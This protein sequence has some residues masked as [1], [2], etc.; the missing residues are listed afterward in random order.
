MTTRRPT[1][2]IA[3]LSLAG[4]CGT[5]LYTVDLA[6]ALLRFDW[7]PVV[8]TPEIGP[9]ADLL[10]AASIPVVDNLEALTFAPDVIHGHHALETIAALLRF[11][12]VPAVYVCHD[13][14]TWHSAPPLIDRIRTYIAVDEHCLDR[15][16]TEYSIPAARARLLPNAVDLSRFRQRRDLPAKPRRALVFSNQATD[17]NFVGAVREACRQREIELD[18]IGAAAGRQSDAPEEALGQVDLVFAKARCA[19][20]AMAVGAAVV[21]CDVA[22]LG[23]MVTTRS[24]E[25]L[26]LQNFGQRTLHRQITAAAVGDEIDR[27]DPADARAVSD[28]V[29]GD[30][31]IHQLAEQF[32]RLYEDLE[33][34]DA[35]SHAAEAASLARELNKVLVRRSAYDART[36]AQRRGFLQLATHFRFTAPLIRWLRGPGPWPLA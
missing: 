17:L 26:R 24:L 5:D 32:I 18:V 2:L 23:G 21:L 1:V 35:A 13:G 19:L 30:A 27:Y 28:A 20:E 33:P 15:M 36:I 3:S 8:F 12:G 29:R 9:T 4:R 25:R 22:G 31:D 6:K 11:P 7:R 34:V 14:L 10:R 16:M